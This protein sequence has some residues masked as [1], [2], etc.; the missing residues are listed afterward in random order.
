MSNLKVTIEGS[1]G[2]GKTTV[3]LLI[4]KSLGEAGIVVKLL[5]EAEDISWTSVEEG[6]HVLVSDDLVVQIETVQTY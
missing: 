6:W 4:T 3:A 1:Q 2:S 5:N